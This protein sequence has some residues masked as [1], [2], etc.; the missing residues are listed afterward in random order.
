MNVRVRARACVFVCL[1]LL[2][3]YLTSIQ[4]PLKNTRA[5][6]TFPPR[7]ISETGDRPEWVPC[8]N[9]ENVSLL[10]FMF[11]VLIACQVE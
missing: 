11:R 1:C 3:Q 8:Q 2:V 4:V 5:G 6:N 10:E 9:I 7:K